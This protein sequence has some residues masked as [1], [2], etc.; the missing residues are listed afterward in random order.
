MHQT[1]ELQQGNGQL[2]EATFCTM[3]A[4]HLTQFSIFWKAMLEEMGEEDTFWDWA[5]K[6]EL[7]L[8]NDR[9][10]AY[11]IEHDNLAQGLIWLETQWHRSYMRSHQ[12]L[13][14]VEALASA[15]WNRSRTNPVPYFVGVGTALLQF[16]RQRSLQLGYRGRLGLHALPGSESF[17][18]SRNMLNFG[19]DP[20]REMVYFEYGLINPPQQ[21]E[22][23]DEL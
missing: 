17:Y 10:E 9:Y 21:W 5:R 19:Y 13:V 16:A 11:A 4:R 23:N 14:Y 1:I 15:P 22:D 8:T 7:S 3:Q 2:V 12:P 20:D 18:E 6:K